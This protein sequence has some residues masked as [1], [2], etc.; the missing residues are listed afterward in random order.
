MT[1]PEIKSKILYELRT[2]ALYKQ[3]CYAITFAGSQFQTPGIPDFLIVVNKRHIWVECKGP[4]TKIRQD[5][6]RVHEQMEKQ[7]VHVYILYFYQ[8]NE[9]MIDNFYRIQ[10]KSLKE[11]VSVMFDT[12]LKITEPKQ[13]TRLEIFK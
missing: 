5:Q 12:L 6:I 10:G 13:L 3:R 1:E 9:W 8:D 7:G 2:N 11:R 4:E